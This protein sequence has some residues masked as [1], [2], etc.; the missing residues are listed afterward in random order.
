MIKGIKTIISTKKTAFDPISRAKRTLGIKKFN[1][2]NYVSFTLTEGKGTSEQ[3][4][5]FENLDKFIDAM[6]FYRKNG[7]P[8]KKENS[9]MTDIEFFHNSIRQR[10]GYIEFRTYGGKG[11]KPTRFPAD[12]FDD[13]IKFM[14]E[15]VTSFK[16]SFEAG[17]LDNFYNSDASEKF[18]ESDDSFG[19]DDENPFE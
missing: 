13:V 18:N 4:I 11:A 7:I 17:D 5:S 10:D 3:P 15:E 14:K 16:N 9:E 6:E 2:N 19:I 12:R 1:N 8:E